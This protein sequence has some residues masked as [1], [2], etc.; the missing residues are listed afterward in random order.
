MKKEP[1]LDQCMDHMEQSCQ[2]TVEHCSQ[3]PFGGGDL[4][5]SDAPLIYKVIWDRF[6][7][8]A[9]ETV[10]ARYG[11]V[12][13]GKKN[14]INLPEILSNGRTKIEFDKV[15][16]ASQSLSS[17]VSPLFDGF[18]V[19]A[20]QSDELIA[21]RRTEGSLVCRSPK[22][23]S[24][25]SHTVCIH[26]FCIFVNEEYG[27]SEANKFA[28]YLINLSS[29]RFKKAIST[30]VDGKKTKYTRWGAKDSEG[31]RSNVVVSTVP[32]V[33]ETDGS[34]AINSSKTR[35]WSDEQT[36][37]DLNQTELD[38]DIV[39]PIQMD[40]QD[41]GALDNT[42]LLDLTLSTTPTLSVF[43]R[44]G[45]K[46]RK[47]NAERKEEEERRI[48][49]ERMQLGLNAED[50]TENPAKKKKKESAEKEAPLHVLNL[51]SV[52]NRITGGDDVTRPTSSILVDA[53]DE[54]NQSI[55]RSSANPTFSL[56]DLS[57]FTNLPSSIMPPFTS[58]HH[59]NNF[60]VVGFITERVNIDVLS[61]RTCMSC[62]APLPPS[63]DGSRVIYHVEK[64][65]TKLS[66]GDPLIR[67]MMS[68]IHC[69]LK[70]LR[71]RYP[72]SHS[73]MLAVSQKFLSKHTEEDERF[74]REEFGCNLHEMGVQI[75][76]GL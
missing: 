24:I 74:L 58:I 19:M 20:G 62:Q 75:K 17:C 64:I 46:G 57:T 15:V 43:D 67:T 5:V 1:S 29:D 18:I 49:E 7:K 33:L 6:D 53:C 41:E 28:A 9:K 37:A 30:S 56:F 27:K 32:T 71:S 61:R 54:Q 47:Y 48:L 31:V 14:T 73:R 25:L 35:L 34:P 11:I 13:R 59:N 36:T 76:H 45:E 55:Y 66:G 21:V 63:I 60:F 44:L 3:A 70:C 40:T 52:Q 72:Y 50:E 69:S 10:L 26:L 4:I 39:D 51:R 2:T 16:S 65:R 12:Q 42:S 22:C 23:N 8:A 68:I 38:E